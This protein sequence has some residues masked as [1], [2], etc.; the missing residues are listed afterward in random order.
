MSSRSEDEF[1][2]DSKQAII[3]DDA[4][5]V[6]L[7]SSDNMQA[8]IFN[9]DHHPVSDIEVDVE[10]IKLLAQLYAKHLKQNSDAQVPLD[11]ERPQGFHPSNLQVN[12]YNNI[13][14]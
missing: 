14:C 13:F 5:A 1:I 9:A 12:I 10:P 8:V 11:I 3:T 7:P 6:S 4:T 2:D